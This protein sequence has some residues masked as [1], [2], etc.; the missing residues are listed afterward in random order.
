MVCALCKSEKA[1]KK[2]THFLTDGIIRSCLNYGG[3]NKRDEGFYFDMFKDRFFIDFNF[4]RNTPITKL[5]KH[6]GRS[7]TEGENKKAKQNPFSVDNIFCNSCE[8]HFTAIENDFIR[9]ILP[10]FRDSDLTNNKEIRLEKIKTIR[11]FFYL[12]LWRT[13]VCCSDFKISDDNKEILRKIILEYKSLHIKDINHFPLSITYLQTLGGEVEF[14]SN[15]VGYT[16]HKNS[17]LIVMNDFI[18]QFYE[19]NIDDIDFFDFFKLNNIENYKCYINYREEETF[20]FN[21][22]WDERRRQFWDEFISGRVERF[23]HDYKRLFLDIHLE[24]YG[25][26]PSTKSMNEFIKEII[27]GD[28]TPLKYTKE[29]ITSMIQNFLTK[30]KTP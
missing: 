29:N 22:F 7:T 27:N 5:E 10:I 16:N 30:H 9:N 23:I 18:I 11:L 3:S 4:Q 1:D 12:Q 25:K 17:N 2:N 13:S 28:I 8:K 19:N 14:T 15:Y 24:C 21:V 20:L 26:L 6:L